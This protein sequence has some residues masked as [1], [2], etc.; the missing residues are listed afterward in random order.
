MENLSF[1]PKENEVLWSRDLAL[2]L[3]EIYSWLKKDKWSNEDIRSKLGRRTISEIQE[4]WETCFMWSCVDVTLL[5]L[6][7]LKE[8]GFDMK[9]VSLWCELLVWKNSWMHAAHFFIKDESTKPWRIIDFS[10]EGQLNIYP[11]PYKNPRDWWSIQ[12]LK[13][14]YLEGEKVEMNDSSLTLAKKIN[15]PISEEYFNQ[16]LTKLC[17]DNTYANYN[18]YLSS[19]WPLKISVDWALMDY[20]H[21]HDD[22]KYLLK[23]VLDQWENEKIIH[24]MN[25]LW[26]IIGP[27]FWRPYWVVVW[28]EKGLK[29]LTDE[30]LEKH[31]RVPYVNCMHDDLKGAYWSQDAFSVTYI[32]L[33]S[34]CVIPITN[35]IDVQEWSWGSWEAIDWYIERFEYSDPEKY[36]KY[37][38][39]R[40]EIGS[41]WYWGRYNR[42]V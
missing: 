4:S 24:A 36:Q 7:K 40:S 17:T 10:R 14:M 23:E 15:L 29:S 5:A 35:T 27:L 22:S 42:G 12:T 34:W 21:V 39:L 2:I 41:I 30:E 9:K 1:Q 20:K 3:K 26:E 13:V 25:E 6:M 8:L 16:Y 11:I 37:F 28:V 31:T 18:N 32:K 38:R 33:N 19:R